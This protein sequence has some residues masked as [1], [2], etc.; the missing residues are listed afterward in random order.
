[1]QM[2]L[3]IIG[4]GE[5]VNQNWWGKSGR[6]IFKLYS[7]FNHNMNLSEILVC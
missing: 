2:I 7:F 1:M 4:A 3:P 5:A 6:K